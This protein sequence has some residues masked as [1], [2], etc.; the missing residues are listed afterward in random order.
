MTWRGFAFS[1]LLGRGTK[2]FSQLQE[3]YEG[4][5]Q[6]VLQEE[7]VGKAWSGDFLERIL[8]KKVVAQIGIAVATYPLWEAAVLDGC[9]L[10]AALP[11]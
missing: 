5:F 10:R 11:S 6:V 7:V 1:E 2:S 4:P 3:A 9:G 8:V